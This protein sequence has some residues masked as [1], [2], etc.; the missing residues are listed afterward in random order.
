MVRAALEPQFTVFFVRVGQQN[1]ICNHIVA[2]FMFCDVD[3]QLQLYLA[4]PI[5]STQQVKTSDIGWGAVTRRDRFYHVA[6]D[7]QQLQVVFCTQ[8]HNVVLH[9]KVT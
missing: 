9:I 1:T 2:C 5:Q 3:K 7:E 6:V 4:N 8:K